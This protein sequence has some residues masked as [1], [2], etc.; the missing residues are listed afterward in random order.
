[1]ASDI[2]PPAPSH[3]RR[4]R[5]LPARDLRRVCRPGEVPAASTAG[6]EPGQVVGQ[7]RVLETLALAVDMRSGTAHHVFATGVAGTGRRAAIEAW[8]RERARERAH[9]AGH[10]L[11]VQLLRATAS[12]RLPAAGRIGPRVRGRR[13]PAGLRRAAAHR[14]GLRERELPH[15]PPGAARRPGPPA[16]GDPAVARAAR[17]RRRRGAVADPRRGHH[18]SDRRRAAAGPGGDGGMPA[19]VRDR[20]EHAVEDLKAPVQ[21]AFAAIH[22]VE[23]DAEGRHA[24]LDPGGLDLRGRH[25]LRRGPPA[26]AGGSRRRRLARR[27]AGGRDRAPRPLPRGH[28]GVGRTTS[29]RRRSSPRPASCA[30]ATPSTCS[31]RASPTPARRS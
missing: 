22:D 10:R 28:R 8:L 25:D 24:E 6:V 15:A 7:P 3:H 31:S 13:R 11:P 2:D 5:A 19:D 23:R 26:V 16:R 14:R 29:R 30:R 9:S 12:P 20:F 18:P 1:M 21:E 27:G 4:P 17:A